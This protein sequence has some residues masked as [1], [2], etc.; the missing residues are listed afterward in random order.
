MLVNSA[1][2]VYDE[3]RRAENAN[4]GTVRE[5]SETNTLGARRM[6]HAFIPPLRKSKHAGH[7]KH[8]CAL[9]IIFATHPARTGGTNA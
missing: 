8:L 6:C 2:I 7:S 9:K 3:W 5:A 4:L 1:A